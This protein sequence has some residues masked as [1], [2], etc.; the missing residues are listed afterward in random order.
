MVGWCRKRTLRVAAH[1]PYSILECITGPKPLSSR[2]SSERPAVQQARS[3]KLTKRSAGGG[4]IR[5]PGGVL[6]DVE[7]GEDFLE[8]RAEPEGMDSLSL[9]AG[10]DHHLNHQSDAA[11][12]EIFDLGKGQKNALGR[13]Q[14]GL[15]RT[16]HRRLRGAGN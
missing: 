14:T 1:T 11:G 16:H 8:V 12:V 5:A 3:C 10:R 15:V 9:F 13:L 4:L 2:N 7:H 6:G